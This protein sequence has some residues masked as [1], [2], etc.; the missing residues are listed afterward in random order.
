M[1]KFL[2][3][4]ANAMAEGP[5]EDDIPHL[6]APRPVIEHFNRRSM[7]AFDQVGYFIF[8]GVRVYE[9]GKKEWA[10]TQENKNLDYV[11]HKKA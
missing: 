4:L 7:T 11:T 1:D 8:Q 5:T 9:E 6:E 3:D 10:R 2:T